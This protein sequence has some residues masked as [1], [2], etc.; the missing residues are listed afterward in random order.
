MRGGRP[1]SMHWFP[2][3][4]VRLS[5]RSAIRA[6]GAAG[7]AAW[8][9]FRAPFENSADRLKGS[10][11]AA[12]RTVVRFAAIVIFGL[13]ALA[14][15]T[16]SPARTSGFSCPAVAGFEQ[17]GE[18]RA[19]PSPAQVKVFCTYGDSSGLRGG[20]I[21][22]SYTPKGQEG[23]GWGCG[24]GGNAY[25]VVSPDHWGY[26]GWTG[27]LDP[28]AARAGA[29]AF[30]AQLAGV[31]EG[32]ETEDTTP[33]TVKVFAASGKHGTRIPIRFQIN[34][35]SGEASFAVAIWR[36][37]KRLSR[38]A[39][40]LRKVDGRTLTITVVPGAK[41]VGNLEVWIVASDAAGNRLASR[42]PLV[43]S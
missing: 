14:G 38:W 18:A 42:A 6:L 23:L 10:G 13:A 36:G 32:C 37:R 16:S 24:Q 34:D 4:S 9:D 39:Y 43:V 12:D 33:P 25:S 29:T 31:S 2:K 1:V 21:F 41:L 19:F 8:T 20:D 22:L 15:A 27:S 3:P 30:L 26:A 35:N 7:Y 17:K 28:A 40:P 11:A 5:A